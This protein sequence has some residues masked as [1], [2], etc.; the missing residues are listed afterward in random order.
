MQ[1]IDVHQQ[2][3]RMAFQRITSEMLSKKRELEEFEYYK[4]KPETLTNSFVKDEYT[5]NQDKLVFSTWDKCE[6]KFSIGSIAIKTIR[7]IVYLIFFVLVM[8]RYTGNEYTSLLIVPLL[9]MTVDS[10]LHLLKIQRENKKLLIAI[11]LICIVFPLCFLAGVIGTKDFAY[12][13]AYFAI[14]IPDLIIHRFIFSNEKILKKVE[15]KLEEKA[16]KKL[17]AKGKY[18]IAIQKDVEEAKILRAEDEKK[19]Q[20]YVQDYT[21]KRNELLPK[22]QQVEAEWKCY[23]NFYNEWKSAAEHAKT[24]YE[25]IFSSD[26]SVDDTINRMNNYLVNE[27]MDSVKD[28]IDFIVCATNIARE[29][30]EETKKD[31]ESITESLAEISAKI[32]KR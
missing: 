16:I 23:E 25:Y 21:K 11:I 20:E 2:V 26:H 32:Y 1:K 17:K 4:A 7:V 27:P 8:T 29:K 9:L 5:P 31:I 28:S 15:E 13:I 30:N 10:I 24:F 19:F 18:K 12:F 14:T 3:S 22:M 6:K